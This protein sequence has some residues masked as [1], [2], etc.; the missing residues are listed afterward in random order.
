MS[1]NNREDNLI[2]KEKEGENG[3][4]NEENEEESEENE[5]ESKVIDLSKPTQ[6][7]EDYPLR[8]IPEQDP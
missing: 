6:Q 2:E 5:E 7:K 8:V 3:E 1:D 4:E